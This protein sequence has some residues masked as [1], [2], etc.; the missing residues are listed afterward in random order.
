MAL[1]AFIYSVEGEEHGAERVVDNNQKKVAG[2][3]LNLQLLQEEYS[4][5]EHLL[6]PQSYAATIITHTY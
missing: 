2:R 6:K 5:L 3:D 1:V 4:L